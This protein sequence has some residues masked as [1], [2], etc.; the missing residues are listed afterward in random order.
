MLSLHCIHA[1]LLKAGLK[2]CVFLM[3]TQQFVLC[4]LLLYTKLKCKKTCLQKEPVLPSQRYLN[5]LQRGAAHSQL[6]KEYQVYLQALQH[7]HASK[8]GQRI[9]RWLSENVLGKPL[10]LLLLKVL[11]YLQNKF[12]IWTIHQLFHNLVLL[13]WDLHDHVLE[14]VLGS[15]CHL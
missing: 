1:F 2:F 13:M 10:R 14:P 7:Y 12:L 8:P 11:P 9:G 15:G 6:A 5:I 3:L 4:A